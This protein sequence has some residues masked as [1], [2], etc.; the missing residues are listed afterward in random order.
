MWITSMGNH[1]AAG[2]SQNASILVVLASTP[3]GWWSQ[4]AETKSPDKVW[5]IF[6]SYIV[7]RI[8][9]LRII[10]HAFLLQKEY[11]LLIMGYNPLKIGTFQVGWKSWIVDEVPG[12]RRWPWWRH[13]TET[14]WALLI[15]CKGNPLVTGEFLLQWP[16]TR[17]FDIS[18]ICAWTNGWA[19]K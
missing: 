17:N 12:L 4:I 7:L 1:G 9:S 11:I 15:V 13:Q 10:L 2:V 19:N 14:F 6:L 18:L 5:T 8:C 3:E 16:V